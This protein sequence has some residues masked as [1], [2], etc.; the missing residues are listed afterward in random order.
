MF[1]LN[2]PIKH[3]KMNQLPVKMQSSQ[4]QIIVTLIYFEFKSDLY[5]HVVFLSNTGSYE[6]FQLLMGGDL[7]LAEYKYATCD[8]FEP[9][10]EVFAVSE[11]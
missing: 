5:N 6:A 7:I 9:K 3:F 10:D 4:K 2:R 8:S 1:N 11:P